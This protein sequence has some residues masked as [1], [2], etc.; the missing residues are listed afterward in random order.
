LEL[1]HI[2]ILPKVVLWRMVFVANGQ[3]GTNGAVP[4]STR[5]RVQ[6]GSH[7]SHFPSQIALTRTLQRCQGRSKGNPDRRIGVVYGNPT[8]SGMGMLP[9]SHMSPFHMSLAPPNSNDL[10]C[11]ARAQA[12]ACRKT[13]ANSPAKALRS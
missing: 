6:K 11:Q 5:V 10:K 7:L 3:P 8:L 2:M 13:S 1:V 9:P 12:T 4:I